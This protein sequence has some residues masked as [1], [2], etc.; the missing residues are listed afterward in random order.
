MRGFKKH[1]TKQ[2]ISPNKCAN[3][4][5]NAKRA[6]LRVH[7]NGKTVL[8]QMWGMTKKPHGFNLRV[9]FFA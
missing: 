5:K 8:C 6:G 2:Q 4:T 7:P 1:F 9:S 3:I